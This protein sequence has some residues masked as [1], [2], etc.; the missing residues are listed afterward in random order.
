M[1]EARNREH[2]IRTRR[3]RIL[4]AADASVAEETPAGE[5][6]IAEVVC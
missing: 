1:S 3:L 6:R 4:S 5:R 2:V